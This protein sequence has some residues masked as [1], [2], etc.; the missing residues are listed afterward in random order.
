MKLSSDDQTLVTV[1]EAGSLIIWKLMYTEGKAVVM[2]KD[3][4]YS[5]EILVSK[6]DLEQKILAIKDLSQKLY[7]LEMDHACLMRETDSKYAEKIKDIHDT[8]CQAIEELKQ[9]TEQLETDHSVQLGS[10]SDDVNQLKEKQGKEKSEMET[11]YTSKLLVE[12]DKFKAL[13][14]QKEAMV[15]DYEARLTELQESKERATNDITKSFEEKIRQVT[16]KLEE[17]SFMF[18]FQSI[19]VLFIKKKK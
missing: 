14:A 10:I 9:K 8:Y 6:M 5:N 12:Y 11:N 7:E 19:N 17:V 1:S 16:K 13:D 18:L 4:R 2:D 15:A 3:F